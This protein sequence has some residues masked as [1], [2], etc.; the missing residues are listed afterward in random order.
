ML[1]LLKI[2]YIRSELQKLKVYQAHSLEK[3]RLEWLQSW[4]DAVRAAFLLRFH[5]A[6]GIQW[7]ENM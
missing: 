2:A 7:Q 4:E 5:V 6:E 1:V 3:L